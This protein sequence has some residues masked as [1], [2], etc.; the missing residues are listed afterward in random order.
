MPRFVVVLGTRPEAIK[1]APVVRALRERAGADDV[2]VCSTGQHREMLA[3]ALG[4]FD[5]SADI[6]L[7][8][9]RP[10]QTPGQVVGRLMLE[11][12]EL[13][14]ELQ[15]E[16]VV[17]QGDTATVTAGALSAFLSGAKVAHVE[18]GLRTNDKRQPFPEEVNR[19]VAGVVADCHFA[20]TP[21]AKD[22][23]LR[24]GVPARDVL[25]TGNTVID[26]LRWMVDRVEDRPLP[27]EIAE[28]RR[29]VLITAHR[30]ESFGEPFRELCEA[31]REVADAVPDAHL[32]YPVHLNPNVREPVMEIL[33]GHERISLIEP[34]D[35]PD[36]VNLMAR[37]HLILTDSGGVQEEAPALAKPVLVLREKTERPE[38]VAAGVVRL[39]G[40]NRAK[41]VTEA[42]RLLTDPAAHAAMATG[43]S[44]YGDGL[45]SKRIAEW[46]VDQSLTTE[47]FTPECAV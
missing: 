23:L 37:S 4:S 36:F 16:W 44:V 1:L 30:R 6:D 8:I 11:L 32:V 40:T 46:L 34:Q 10:G 47:E 22:N 35:Y 21:T 9:M 45:A 43:A 15:P 24:E 28:G 39:V 14:G 29:L 31:L 12:G 25:V 18:A 33:G 13:F 20:A 41:I 17:V 38:A 7:N 2:S 42:T 5:L 26:A 3:H 27:L 19:R